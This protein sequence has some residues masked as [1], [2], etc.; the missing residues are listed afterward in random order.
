MAM[1][2]CWPQLPKILTDPGVQ[3][4]GAIAMAPLRSAARASSWSAV[5][6]ARMKSGRWPSQVMEEGQ[7]LSVG[8]VAA[9]AARSGPAGCPAPMRSLTVP[10]SNQS[11]MSRRGWRLASAARRCSNASRPTAQV[12]RCRRRA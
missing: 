4:P 3:F 12:P 2:W 9:A 8:P 10:P 5:T 7:D 11:W 1:F 6:T